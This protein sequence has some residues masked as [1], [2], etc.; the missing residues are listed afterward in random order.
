MQ[1]AFS[2]S[3]LFAPAASIFTLRHIDTLERKAIAD[4]IIFS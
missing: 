4:F 3:L 1:G 2:L